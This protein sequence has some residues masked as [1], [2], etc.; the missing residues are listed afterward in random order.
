MSLIERR[1][2]KSGNSVAV[3]LPK[4]FGFMPGTPITIEQIGTTL[5]IRPTVDPVEEKRKPSALIETLRA[6]GPV[7]EIQK[8]EPIEFPD[9]PGLYCG[10]LDRQKHRDL[11]RR[12]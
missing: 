1:T 4:K 10:V 6:L 12:R 11:P 2:F 7:G 5:T 9:R 3:R 8:R